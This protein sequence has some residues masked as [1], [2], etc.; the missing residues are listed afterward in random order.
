MKINK[1]IQKKIDL[2]AKKRLHHLQAKTFPFEIINCIND[3][4]TDLANNNIIIED[5]EDKKITHIPKIPIDQN[6]YFQTKNIMQFSSMYLGTEY[7][8]VQNN[9][10][11]IYGIIFIGHI[12]NIYAT[13][14]LFDCLRKIAT[15]IRQT[16]ITQLKRYKKQSTKDERADEYMDEWFEGLIEKV[17]YHAWY[18]LSDRK[19]F[20]DY[21]KKHFK[22]MEDVVNFMLRAIE[23]I[24]PIYEVKDK[25]ITWGEFKKELNKTFPE[26]YINETIKEF[27]GI[28]TKD[29]VIRFSAE[30]ESIDKIEIYD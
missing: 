16:Y 19:C 26:E 11:G 7:C 17:R 22:M 2:Y 15:E 1:H 24:K 20:S 29:V 8:Y 18:D 25:N 6:S 5:I 4:R 13:Q 9:K 27:K 3:F 10:S 21:V 12:N 23:I 30:E 28:R 14:I